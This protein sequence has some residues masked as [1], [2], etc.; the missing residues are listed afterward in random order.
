VNGEVRVVS[1]RAR[2]SE[3]NAEQDLLFNGGIAGTSRAAGL[4][5]ARAVEGVDLDHL[6]E[7]G[8]AVVGYAFLRL[9][10][11]PAVKGA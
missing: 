6:I 8:R 1:G 2:S 10:P 3:N 4:K 5:L 11:E 9:C 7:K